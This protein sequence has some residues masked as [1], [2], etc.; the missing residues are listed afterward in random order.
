ML[1]VPSVLSQ[2]TLMTDTCWACS[3]RA[4]PSLIMQL[5]FGIRSA[6]MLFNAYADALEWIL[7]DRGIARVIHYLDDHLVLG[8]GSHKCESHLSSM[9]NIC[10]ILGIPLAEDKIV[11]P[12]T[13]LSF[14]VSG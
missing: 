11:G 2:Y 6:L 9:L 13:E 3:G 5:P 4:L 1:P 7:R 14:V 8:S 10:E 12:A